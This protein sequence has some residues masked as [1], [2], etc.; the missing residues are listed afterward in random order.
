MNSIRRSVELLVSIALAV[1]CLVPVTAGPA[2]AEP[3]D[4]TAKRAEEAKREVAVEAAEKRL[5]EVKAELAVLNQAVLQAESEV[6]LLTNSMG[7]LTREITTLEQRRQEHVDLSE[8]YEAYLEA[9][10]SST[11][12]AQS[13]AD[14]LP[15]R[16]PRVPFP[17]VFDSPKASFDRSLAQARLAATNHD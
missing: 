4:C 9:V 11:I 3:C 8:E 6:L 17:L 5:A 15:N 16:P 10:L 12:T 2:S 13:L 14:G 1:T 7:S